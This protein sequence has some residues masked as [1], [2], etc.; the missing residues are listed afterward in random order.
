M[1]CKVLP[2]RERLSQADFA[3]LAG[4][5]Q[6]RRTQHQ[7]LLT[8]WVFLPDHWHAILMPPYPGTL[9]GV[10][11]SIKVSSTRLINKLRGDRGVLWQGRFFDRALRTVKEYHDKVEY[12]HL[13]PV[14]RGLVTKQEEWKWSSVHDYTGTVRRPT[15][16]KSVLP[17][18]RVSLPTDERARIYGGWDCVVRSVRA[19]TQPK[20]KGPRTAEFLRS[21]TLRYPASIE[22]SYRVFKNAISAF[23]SSA[24]RSSPKGWPF[25]A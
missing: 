1:T 13:N 9:S 19:S 21:E 24:E 16:T 11:E 12:I 6:S 25:T 18:D 14:K 20:P 7:F 3:L 23:L 15:G 17:V 4:S 2:E 22:G 8:A 10:M 5:I